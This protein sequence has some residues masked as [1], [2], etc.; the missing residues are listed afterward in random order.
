M[1]NTLSLSPTQNLMERTS[2]S[3]DGVAS[4]SYRINNISSAMNNT[5]KN[6]HLQDTNQQQKSKGRFNKSL[7]PKPEDVLSKLGI[8]VTSTNY[9]GYLVVRCPF[10]KEGHEQNPS[11]NI[12][13]SK[14]YY[15]CHACGEKGSDILAFYQKVTG[16]DFK[17]AAKE[18][19]AWEENYE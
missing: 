13:A 9:S 7:L 5:H 2:Q 18:L 14:G 16:K 12:H 4:P 10:H 15:K 3:L 19:N 17:Q 8:R 1:N 6:T 11:M